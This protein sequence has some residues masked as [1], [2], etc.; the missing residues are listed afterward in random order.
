[1][2]IKQ[3]TVEPNLLIFQFVNNLR[4]EEIGVDCKFCKGLFLTIVSLK[5]KE[6]AC[7]G[8]PSSINFLIGDGAGYTVVPPG[9][10]WRSVPR[11]I[12]V[13]P[14]GIASRIHSNPFRNVVNCLIGRSRSLVIN[15]AW[16]SDLSA[17]LRG[18]TDDVHV[19]RA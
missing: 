10:P 17:P 7:R 9:V 15:F 6:W 1:M 16:C 18:R 11:C 13:P 3:D 2:S 5:G 8:A 12:G 19:P 4:R 14:L